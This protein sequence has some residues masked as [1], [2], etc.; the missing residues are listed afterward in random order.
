MSDFVRIVLSFDPHF[1]GMN[2]NVVMNVGET[3]D[4][5]GINVIKY[6]LYVMKTVK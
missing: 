5:Y 6:K 2:Q 1:G 4:I 3:Q